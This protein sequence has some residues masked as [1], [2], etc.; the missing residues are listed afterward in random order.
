MNDYTNRI[1]IEGEESPPSV[2]PDRDVRC[3]LSCLPMVVKL[4]RP[5]TSGGHFHAVWVSATS[6]TTRNHWRTSP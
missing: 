5:D 4:E 2:G 1:L 6:A 3:F